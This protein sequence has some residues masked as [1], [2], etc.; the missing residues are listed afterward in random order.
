MIKV[1]NVTKKLEEYISSNYDNVVIIGI[2]VQYSCPAFILLGK[3][4]ENIY[5]KRLDLLFDYYL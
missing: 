1:E 3:I 2:D 4:I 5:K